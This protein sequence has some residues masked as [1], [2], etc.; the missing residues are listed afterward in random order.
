MKPLPYYH[1]YFFNT[2][3]QGKVISSPAL[4]HSQSCRKDSSDRSKE[5]HT[6]L[7]TLQTG[8]TQIFSVQS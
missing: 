1:M 3:E 8:D 6:G 5:N 4:K 2:P 7:V